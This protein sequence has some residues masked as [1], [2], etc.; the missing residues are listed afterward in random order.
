[1][2]I[3]LYQL[4]IESYYG[5]NGIGYTIGRLPIH[6]C[7]FSEDIYTFDDIENDYDLEYFDTN[8]KYDQNLSL[9]LIIDALK[10]NPNL[11]LFGS[12]WSPPA[13]MKTNNNMLYGGKL[14]YF[15]KWIQ[16]YE[17]QGVPLWVSICLCLCLCV[18]GYTGMCIFVSVCNLYISI[19]YLISNTLMHNHTI[20]TYVHIITLLIGSYCTE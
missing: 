17:N 4:I 19:S 16:A 11:K 9:P 3:N 8:V 20:L 6:S 1:M 5:T 7:D 14:L 10:I 2:Y 13:W 12:P 18:Y 15:S